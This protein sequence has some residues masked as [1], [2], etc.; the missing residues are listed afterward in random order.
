MTGRIVQTVALDS[1]L[2]QSANATLTISGL[3]GGG[4]APGT[5]ADGLY[6]VSVRVWNTSNPASTL[7]REI[8]PTPLDLRTGVFERLPAQY[9]LK[10]LVAARPA[11]AFNIIPPNRS[12]NKTSNRPIPGNMRPPALLM[13]G[14]LLMPFLSGRAIS[15][16]LSVLRAAFVGAAAILALS[17]LRQ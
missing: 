17:E 11:R 12:A 6:Y 4:S 1:V 2:T 10:R 3:P 13:K 9:R 15:G 14:D 8:Y 16:A 5:F 7:N